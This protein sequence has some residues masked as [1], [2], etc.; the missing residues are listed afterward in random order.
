MMYNPD[1]EVEHCNLSIKSNRAHDFQML[2]KGYPSLRLLYE[3][4]FYDDY[5][6]F[7]YGGKGS[8]MREFDRKI[9]GLEYVY[10]NP[11]NGDK[12]R[13][14]WKRLFSKNAG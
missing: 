13:P 6:L 1:N 4:T 8:E 9:I 3:P 11:L 14:W 5:I 12:R 10:I 2:M 7:S